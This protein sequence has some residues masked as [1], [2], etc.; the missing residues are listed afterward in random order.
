MYTY[1]FVVYQA[2]HTDGIEYSEFWNA[3]HQTCMRVCVRVCVCTRF[4]ERQERRK[5]RAYAGTLPAGTAEITTQNIPN[6]CIK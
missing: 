5:H 1:L 4:Q 2:E 6:I 3:L